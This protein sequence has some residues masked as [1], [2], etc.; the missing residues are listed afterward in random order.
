MVAVTGLVAFAQLGPDSSSGAPSPRPSPTGAAAPLA[1]RVRATAVDQ[2]RASLPLPKAP[3]ARPKAA[4]ARRSGTTRPSR[5]GVRGDVWT[6]LARCESGGDPTARSA[7]GLYTGA[8]QFSDATW[9]SLG[10]AGSA[11]DHSYGVQ[12]EAAQRLQAR[13]GWGQWPRCARKLGLR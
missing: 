10:Y 7:N 3:A 8:F 1:P 5:S 13:S 4:D 9:Q 6:A 2:A 12:V 11:A